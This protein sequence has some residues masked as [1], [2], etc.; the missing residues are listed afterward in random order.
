MGVA[1]R[2]ELIA[3]EL[4]GDEYEQVAH[5]AGAEEYRAELPFAVSVVPAVLVTALVGQV[6][7]DSSA[8]TSS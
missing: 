2:L 6:T 1:R 4:R 8:G 3:Y 5:V 7:R